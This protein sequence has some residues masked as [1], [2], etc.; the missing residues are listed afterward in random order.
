MKQLLVV[1]LLIFSH[2]SLSCDEECLR[3]MAQAKTGKKFPGYL[4]WK[5]CDRVSYEFMTSVM[6][7]LS[8]FK[9]RKMNPDYKGPF[10]NILSTVNT[11]KSWLLECDSYLRA[12]NQ[13]PVFDNEKS[14]E[15][16]FKS[17]DVVTKEVTN[18][19]NG[20]TYS[21]MESN[22]KT[23]YMDQSFDHLFNIV[24]KHK[25]MMQLKGQFVVK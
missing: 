12:T 18:I 24:D 5:E 21:N 25:T 13:K 2:N 17:M 1:A 6:T 4:T 14:T 22:S 8:K 16:I 11:Q 23:F 10:K 3:D 15:A 9:E 20:V 19:I 7:S